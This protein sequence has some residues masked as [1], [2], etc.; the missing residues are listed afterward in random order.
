MTTLTD[1]EKALVEAARAI[2]DY[3]SPHGTSTFYGSYSRLMT[4]LRAYDPPKEKVYVLPT[5]E[6]FINGKQTGRASP[7][8]AS[9][10]Y[11]EGGGRLVYRGVYNAIRE[12]T[13]KEQE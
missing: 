1:R 8:V 5:W 7:F 9:E 11:A 3:N 13:A 10:V 2:A 6:E 4:A 12:A